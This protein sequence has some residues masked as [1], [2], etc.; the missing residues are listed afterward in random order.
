MAKY[1]F[2]LGLWLSPDFAEHVCKRRENCKYYLE[3][4][5]V[6][7]RAMLDDFDFLICEENCKHYLPK[8]EEVPPKVT[9]DED[10]F[11]I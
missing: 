2:C 9:N 3:D 5:F 1:Y 7:Y 6:R 11:K 10:I 4:F 8:K